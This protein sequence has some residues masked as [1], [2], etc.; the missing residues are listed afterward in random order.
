VRTLASGGRQ[1]D[2]EA[3]LQ[4]S[5]QLRSRQER[6]NRGGSIRGSGKDPSY[7]SLYIWGS[8]PSQT[9]CVTVG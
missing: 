8:L 9:R 5:S 3:Q 4:S 1:S 7:S 6:G 2:S